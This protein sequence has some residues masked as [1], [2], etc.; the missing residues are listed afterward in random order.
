LR[1]GRV[2]LL[3]RTRIRGHMLFRDRRKTERGSTEQQNRRQ[4]TSF[5]Y[6]VL[7]EIE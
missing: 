7:H 1:A 4:N 3:R 5:H 6:N 2:G